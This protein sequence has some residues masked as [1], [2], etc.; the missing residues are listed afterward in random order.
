[1]KLLILMDFKFTKMI[2]RGTE[3]IFYVRTIV[4]TYIFRFFMYTNSLD[5]FVCG[6]LLNERFFNK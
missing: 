6:K 4:Y 1:M 5:C 2:S 3:K